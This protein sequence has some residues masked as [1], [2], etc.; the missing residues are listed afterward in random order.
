VGEFPFL[1]GDDCKQF[2]NAPAQHS[3]I[4]KLICQKLVHQCAS[5]MLRRKS[6]AGELR[7]AHLPSQREQAETA[8]RVAQIK[9][10]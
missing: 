2:V 6:S 10:L 8:Y 5:S 9:I 1:Q 3:H 7:I 4:V